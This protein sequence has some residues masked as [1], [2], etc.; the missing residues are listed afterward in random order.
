MNETKPRVPHHKARPRVQGKHGQPQFNQAQKVISKFGGEAKLAVILGMS[1]TAIY[2]WTY[3][4]PYGSDGLIPSRARV[5]IEQAA[6]V[7]G[8]DLTPQ[9]WTPE[10]ITYPA[11]VTP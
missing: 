2:L 7:L 3:A 9:D 5:R 4:A 11:T 1:R 10:L 6:G 8:V